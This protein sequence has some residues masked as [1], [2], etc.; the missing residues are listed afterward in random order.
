MY[1]RTILKAVSGALAIFTLAGVTALWLEHSAEKSELT[2]Q[3]IAATQQI[4]ENLTY[5]IGT[6]HSMS[7]VH[8]ASPTGFDQNK[9]EMFAS[10]L[11]TNQAT[12]SAV[13]RFDIVPQDDLEYLQADLQ[14]HGLYH[15]EPKKL[16]EA[17]AIETLA[18]K[19]QYTMLT[20]FFPQD[21][22]TANFIGLDFSEIKSTRTAIEE[23]LSYNSPVPA[24]LP[25]K[26]II[27]GQLNVFSS[28]YYGHFVP[29][30]LEDRRLQS[31]GGYFITLDM[32][33]VISAATGEDF[34]LSIEISPLSFEDSGY[35]AMQGS[36]TTKQRIASTLF[37]STPIKHNLIIGAKSTTITY[38]T[39]AGV[40][41]AQQMS[42]VAKSLGVLLFYL[43]AMAIYTAIKTSRRQIISNKKALAKERKRALVTLNS[44][45]DA[46]I[47]TDQE[48]KIDFVNPAILKVLGRTRAEL[49]DLPLE[50]LLESEFVVLQ[51]KAGDLLNSAED[52]LHAATDSCLRR[53][54]DSEGQEIIFNCHSSDIVAQDGNKIGSVLTMR[55]VSKEYA[56]TTELA[57][58]ATHDA[59]TSLPN[60]RKFESLVDSILKNNAALENN[61]QKKNNQI[62]GY[63]D[64][65]Q[66]K[67]INDT[68]GHA[69]GDTLLKKIATD[70]TSLIPDYIEIAR[71]G[72]DEFGFIST[73][74][75]QTDAHAIARLFHDFF[76]SYYYTTKE[77]TFSIRAS[78]GLT[79]I[80]A[81]HNAV[82]EVLSEVDIACYT[83]KD[84]GR[85]GYVIYDSED[86]ETQQ[87]EG[88]MLY[89]PM[90][91]TALQDNRFTLYTQPIASTLTSDNQSIHHYE[92]LLRLIHTTG[93]V[94]T[95]YKFI[96]AAER[97]DLIKE[98]D[99]WVIENAFKQISQLNE[100]LKG[101]LFS[102]NLSGQSAV[103][104]TMPEFIE[105]M[106][107]E[108]HIDSA[109]IC[110]EL[111]E[112]AVISNFSQA[113]KLI[114]FVRNRGCTIALDDFGAGA[115]SF[116]YLKNLEVDY[117]KIDGQFVREMT[118][119]KVD[120]EM[121]RSMNAVGKALG[122]KTIA[123]FVESEEIL[124]ALASIEVDYAQGYF[125][126]KPKPMEDLANGSHL[127]TA[128]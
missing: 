109:C 6:L 100:T 111:T 20:A 57:H 60:R 36:E 94:V 27:P 16:N 119:N 25:P 11:V 30:T 80:R 122:I 38:R 34:P 52:D 115:S 86:L 1:L 65:D 43:L 90:L 26:W 5:A 31:D 15:F 101:T 59:L 8:Q 50:Q 53:L 7:A 13:G 33:E 95:P 84:A 117:L 102:I 108:H 10:N 46:V 110:F 9:F 12:I 106:L 97:Y 113:Q 4:H 92:C 120:F 99:R 125:L 123:E 66:F 89:L 63:I 72:G 61:N 21:P 77:Q 47:T 22:V 32:N 104:P 93:E 51:Q 64:L 71:L 103:D 87:R 14:L 35:V 112:T 37:P 88:E 74:S 73:D 41:R 124:T 91:Q 18:L 96:V 67:L 62:V 82:N 127:R 42:A 28:T 83:A 56:L 54:S 126:G 78:I 107:T 2:R 45:Q 118:S 76:Q 48:D 121:V 128:A 81:N 19:S 98:I 70:L 40:T 69:A 79:K 24:K 55:D 17:G 29:V 75:D 116:G 44:L 3:S 68:V 39:P 105:S 114:A 23:S 85:N 58:Q 49:I